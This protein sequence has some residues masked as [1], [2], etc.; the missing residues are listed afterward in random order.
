MSDIDP[1]RYEV[2]RQSFSGSHDFEDS[3]PVGELT[4]PKSAVVVDTTT[5]H[6]FPPVVT[7]TY[8][9]PTDATGVDEVEDE[10]DA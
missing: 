10:P 8:L 9:V 1:G 3:D 7:V 6:V 5:Q 2:Y 4:I